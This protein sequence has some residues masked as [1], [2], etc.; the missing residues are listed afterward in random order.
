MADGARMVSVLQP[1]K[2]DEWFKNTGEALP[3]NATGLLLALP[4]MS[5]APAQGNI[6]IERIGFNY[7]HVKP[8]VL[9]AEDKRAVID[10]QVIEFLHSEEV[11]GHYHSKSSLDQ[12]E[13]LGMTRN[14]TRNAITRLEVAGRIKI[15]KKPGA[16]QGQRIQLVDYLPEPM[17]S[18]RQFP[19]QLMQ[20]CGLSAASYF[21]PPP[22]GKRKTARNAPLFS[23][24]FLFLA[25][26]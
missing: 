12:C 11:Q 2:P 14:E 13:T 8:T 26:N 15:I 3:D 22:I 16:G 20:C 6:F 18:N 4:K 25:S 7:R 19:E 1:I 5:Y 9:N 10:A 24:I 17:A 23:L 21:S